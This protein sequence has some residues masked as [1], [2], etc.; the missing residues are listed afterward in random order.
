MVNELLAKRGLEKI[1]SSTATAAEVVQ[2]ND[3]PF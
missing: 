1:L 2:D 3:I